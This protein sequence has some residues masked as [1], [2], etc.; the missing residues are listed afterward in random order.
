MEQAAEL[1]I[2][3][4][5]DREDEHQAINVKVMKHR[6]GRSDLSA[7]LPTYYD[8]SFVDWGRASRAT[9]IRDVCGATNQKKT[10]NTARQTNGTSMQRVIQSI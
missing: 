3:M 9:L 1:I 6:S 5:S 10:G 2:Y 8:S 7:S 4:V